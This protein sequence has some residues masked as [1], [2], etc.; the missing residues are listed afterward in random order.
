MS[1][2][3]RFTGDHGLCLSQKEGLSVITGGVLQMT[4]GHVKDCFWAGYTMNG[5]FYL[6][7]N[8]YPGSV[9]EV[10]EEDMLLHIED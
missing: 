9:W 7:L 8:N 10:T 1:K 4:G 2:P 5:K 3:T 6:S